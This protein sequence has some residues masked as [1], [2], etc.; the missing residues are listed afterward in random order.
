MVYRY[1]ILCQPTRINIIFILVYNNTIITLIPIFVFPARLK[2]RA[3]KDYVKL[4]L[5]IKYILYILQRW[6]Y[7][8]HL[9]VNTY[10]GLVP[11]GL[12]YVCLQCFH[13]VPSYLSF[14]HFATAPI[15]THLRIY[16]LITY[17]IWF[18]LPC[19]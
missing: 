6:V 7:S 18:S 14:N 10:S 19:I 13:Q 4:L 17:Y 9:N 16:I 11:G 5:K 15:P 2:C 12:V 3:C 8:I 1:N